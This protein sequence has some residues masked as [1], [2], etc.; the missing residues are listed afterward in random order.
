MRTLLLALL[1]Q[2]PPYGWELVC[3]EK[4]EA[5]VWIDLPP[6]PCG[7]PLPAVSAWVFWSPTPNPAEGSWARAEGG[8]KVAVY[9]TIPHG[10]YV[11]PVWELAGVPVVQF[12]ASFCP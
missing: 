10:S 4:P 5:R 6:P 1:A 11:W 9:A 12:H 2:G 3:S 8:A 7:L